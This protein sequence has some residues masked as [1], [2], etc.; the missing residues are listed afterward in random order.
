MVNARGEFATT[1]LARP[2]SPPVEWLIADNPVPY[3][4]AV[5]AMTQA[6]E[7]MDVLNN[8]LNLH[9]EVS[10]HGE[11]ESKHMLSTHGLQCWI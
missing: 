2:G 8:S 7:K 1:F 6:L 3:P 9:K 11:S 4:D 10:C 5:A